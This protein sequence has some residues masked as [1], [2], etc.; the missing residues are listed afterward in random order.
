MTEL[1]DYK[2]MIEAPMIRRWEEKQSR[3]VAEN[4]RLLAAIAHVR[5]RSA[6]AAEI[7]NEFDATYQQSSNTEK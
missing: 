2:R 6:V 4:Q 5:S 7:L 3:M 1:S